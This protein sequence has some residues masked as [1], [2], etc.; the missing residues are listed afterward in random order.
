MKKVS[1]ALVLTV[2]S[3]VSYAECEFRAPRVDFTGITTKAQMDAYINQV[4]TLSPEMDPDRAFKCSEA[5]ANRQQWS[6]EVGR[7][8]RAMDRRWTEDAIRFQDQFR[9]SAK[10]YLAQLESQQSASRTPASSASDAPASAN[11]TAATAK[12]TAKGGSSPVLIMTMLRFKWDVPNTSDSLVT[13]TSMA[14]TLEEA[15]AQEAQRL[16]ERVSY[17]TNMRSHLVSKQDPLICTGR[18]WYAEIHGGTSPETES[19]QPRDSA[20]CGYATREEAIAAA[21]QAYFSIG[22]HADVGALESGL[23]TGQP[24]EVRI[25][26]HSA[27]GDQWQEVGISPNAR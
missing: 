3:T 9:A 27:I 4:L 10:G 16:R 11:G 26:D 25:G 15:L 17:Q 24:R 18:L 14:P 23:A 12:G 6:G 7:Q 21:R 2:I 13:N 20:V 5:W 8:E 19:Y 1:I 22:G